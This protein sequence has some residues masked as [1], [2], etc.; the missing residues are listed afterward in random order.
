[1]KEY[2]GTKIDVDTEH[3]SLKITQ[4]VLVQSLKDEFNFKEVTA[5]P[6]VPAVASTH[7]LP[8]G[9]KLCGAEQM[10][11]GSGIGKLLYLMKWLHPEIANS[12]CELTRFMT[13]HTQFV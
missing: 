13:S 12:V 1:M 6:E 7:L 9:P 5:K 11:Y 4:P 8:N 2:I 3:K 10:K